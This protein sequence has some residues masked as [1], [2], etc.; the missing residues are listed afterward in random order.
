[1][2]AQYAALLVSAGRYPEAADL[3]RRLQ[4]NHPRDHGSLLAYARALKSKGKHDEVVAYL[5]PLLPRASAPA[6][7]QIEYLDALIRAQRFEEAEANFGRAFELFPEN[8]VLLSLRAVFNRLIGNMEASVRDLMLALLT[9]SQTRA[10]RVNALRTLDRGFK[11]PDR[12]SILQ[13]IS[14]SPVFDTDFAE[15][16][17]VAAEFLEGDFEALDRRFRIDPEFFYRRFAAFR[18]FCTCCVRTSHSERLRQA[19]L[20]LPSS[21]HFDDDQYAELLEMTHWL[22]DSQVSRFLV[23]R[24]AAKKGEPR[25]KAR[26]LLAGFEPEAEEPC[27]LLVEACLEEAASDGDDAALRLFLSEQRQILRNRLASDETRRRFDRFLHLSDNVADEPTALGLLRPLRRLT[28]AVLKPE[29]RPTA[30]CGTP[31]VSII[32]PVHRIEDLPNLCASVNRQTWQ[33]KELV[34]VANGALANVEDL[35]SQLEVDCPLTLLVRTEG[36]LGQFLNAAVDASA[37]DII[38]RFD[39]DDIYHENYLRNMVA[40]LEVM[41]ADVVGKDSVFVFMEASQKIVL[42][43]C[44]DFFNYADSVRYHGTGSTLVFRR[45]VAQAVRFHEQVHRGEDELFYESCIRGGIAVANAD[46]FNHVV[47]RKS[48][49]AEHTWRAADFLSWKRLLVLGGPEKMYLTRL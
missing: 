26:H 24:M 37:G 17:E 31:M 47:V 40:S 10:V 49:K 28:Q 14:L 4:E 38:A 22:R 30:P 6:Q 43:Q 45:T 23:Q 15:H 39:G 20:A 36:R 7:V 16:R 35:R 46:P 11:L 41:H 25:I 32:A 42:A 48:D 19:I 34:V 29:A 2:M 18:Q 33:H 21:A 27:D 8:P 3:A 44:R 13:R 5:R 9:G 1:M 12:R